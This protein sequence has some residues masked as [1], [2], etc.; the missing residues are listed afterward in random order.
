[1]TR[2][3]AALKLAWKPGLLAGSLLFSFAQASPPDNIEAFA[4][5][6]E[7]HQ[8]VTEI[9]LTN[10][11]VVT[12]VY[13][14]GRFEYPPQQGDVIREPS[15]DGATL[16]TLSTPQMSEHFIPGLFGYTA[17]GGPAVEQSQQV[18]KANL[19]TGGYDENDHPQLDRATARTTSGTGTTAINVQ[20][21]GTQ[22]YSADYSLKA[23]SR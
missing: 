3:L 19:R 4:T 1:M 22:S 7:S 11:D 14:Q 13:S 20:L 15:N 12:V 6:D 17:A 10:G 18:T 8:T 5:E 21:P 23:S 2:A 16:M 9:V